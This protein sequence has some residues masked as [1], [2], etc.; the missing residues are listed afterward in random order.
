MHV[1][2]LLPYYC[3]ETISKT[4]NV[5]MLLYL[6]LICVVSFLCVGFNC[7]LC[8]SEQIPLVWNQL[9]MSRLA[10][11]YNRFLLF[12]AFYV[13]LLLTLSCGVCLDVQ[14]SVEE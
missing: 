2:L 8:S 11:T 6:R 14:T 1:S 3:L 12:C 9:R 7:W 10:V 13:I 4:A 5:L